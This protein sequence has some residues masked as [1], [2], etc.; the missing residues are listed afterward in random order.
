MMVQDEYP[1]SAIQ[2]GGVF[3]EFQNVIA[4]NMDAV[5]ADTDNAASENHPNGALLHGLHSC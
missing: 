1:G 3:Y 2:S 4:E 5:M